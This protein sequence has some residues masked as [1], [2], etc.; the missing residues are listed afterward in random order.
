MPTNISVGNWPFTV[1]AKAVRTRFSPDGSL[2]SVH[3]MTDRETGRW[4]G[5]GFVAMAIEAPEVS[6]TL[7]HTDLNGRRLRVRRAIARDA[8]SSRSPSR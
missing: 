7:D 4:H 1:M 8:R 5:F 2:A 3:R 6:T